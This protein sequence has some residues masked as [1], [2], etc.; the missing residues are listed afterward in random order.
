VLPDDFPLG[1]IKLVRL[2]QD[3]RVNR[4]LADVM[5]KCG[6]AKPIPVVCGQVKFI[7]N[8]IREDTHPF[9]M[10]T[11]EAI[12][13]VERSGKSEDPLGSHN[14]LVVDPLCLGLFDAPSKIPGTP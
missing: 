10:A 6:P 14:W 1:I 7:S 5:E 9:A 13:C 3:M 2:V 4:Q 12:V 8:Q 11:S